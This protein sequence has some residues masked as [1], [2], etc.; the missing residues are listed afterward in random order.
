MSQAIF[1]DSAILID[2]LRGR[3]E[4]TALIREYPGRAVSAVVWME[5]ILCVVDT[6]FEAPARRLL[7]LFPKVEVSLAIQ[8]RAIRLC[9]HKGLRLPDAII[10]ATA[11]EHSARL[12]T[13]NEKYFDAEDPMISVP[14]RL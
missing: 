11:Q 1:F 14:Y 8:E 2:H 4:A 10:Y 7:S 12:I 3:K 9:Q 13:R 6:P 5:V